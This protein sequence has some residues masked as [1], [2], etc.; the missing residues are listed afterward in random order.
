M[1]RV[2]LLC[3]IFRIYPEADPGGKGREIAIHLDRN[4]PQPAIFWPPDAPG[5]LVF[6]A[7]LNGFLIARPEVAVKDALTSI[8]K[9]LEN[10]AYVHQTADAVREFVADAPEE[11]STLLQ[12][13]GM[14]N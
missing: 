1:T 11:V 7:L 10:P 2:K 6:V 12:R 13:A 3:Q 5:M 4:A 14:M 8:C 9:A